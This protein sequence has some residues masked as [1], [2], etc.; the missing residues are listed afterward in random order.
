MVFIV[1]FLLS[2]D[3]CF[4][5]SIYLPKYRL[6]FTSRHGCQICWYRCKSYI[7]LSIKLK[8]HTNSIAL[9]LFDSRSCISAADSVERFTCKNKNLSKTKSKDRHTLNKKFAALDSKC[10]N[11]IQ[12]S[13][14]AAES[15]IKINNCRFEYKNKA[16]RSQHVHILAWPI[17]KSDYQQTQR[18]ER[19]RGAERMKKKSK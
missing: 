9:L 13:R 11:L 8:Q 14:W 4:D 17:P 19:K 7:C 15:Q 18:E 5:F 10:T 2:F 6:E 3:I 1:L 12:F 16:R